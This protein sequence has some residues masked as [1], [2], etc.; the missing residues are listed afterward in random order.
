MIVYF[1]YQEILESQNYVPDEIELRDHLGGFD[2]NYNNAVLQVL[3]HNAKNRE[4]PVTVLYHQFLSNEVTNL[5]SDLKIK[6]NVQHQIYGNLKWFESYH[7]HPEPTFKNFLCSFNGSPHVSRKLLASSLDRFGW[8]NPETCSKNFSY[9]TDILDGHIRELVDNSEFYRKFFI[10]D[11]S[12]E[13]FGTI[14][15][16]GAYHRN[17]HSKNIHNLEH[18]LTSSFLHV[19]S[20]TLATS[21][22]PFVTE[23]FL[24]SVV[25]RGLF[26]AYAQP[27]WHAHVE[28]YYG[29]R[30]YKHIFDYRFDTIQN[31][32]ERLIEL[33][34]MISKF[35]VLSCDD[36]RDLY[37]MEID[38][39]EYNYDHYF[40]GRY[41]EVL[42]NSA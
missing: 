28:H 32:V 10:H 17:N 21:Y 1:P 40:S 39:I 13:F 18:K 7:I 26:L 12:D 23:K 16:C 35:S 22:Y 30:K 4:T 20:E 11:R 24:Y 6:F 27:G 38:T 19:V 2:Q 5:Y 37:E 31:P 25:T 34:S 14:N 41:L 3:D 8:F 42:R 36:W 9:T 33:M 29:F 15:S